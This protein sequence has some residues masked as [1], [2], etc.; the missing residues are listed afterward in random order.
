MSY[1]HNLSPFAIQ[2]TEHFG[3]RWYGLAYLAGFISGY[4]AIV[5]MTRKG[6]TRFKVEQVAD[7]ITYVAIGVLIGGRLGYCVFY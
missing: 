6:G 1:V 3:V 5:Y 2:F 7:F 4:F